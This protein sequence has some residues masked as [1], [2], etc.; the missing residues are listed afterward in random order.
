[1]DPLLIVFISLLQLCLGSK[2]DKEIVVYNESAKIRNS[3]KVNIMTPSMRNKE[4]VNLMENSKV[5][6]SRVIG[7]EVT[8]IEKLGGYLVALRYRDE[9]TCGGT[10]LEERFVVSA[11]HCFLGRTLKSAWTVSGGIS[12]LSETGVQVDLLDYVVPAVFREKSMHMDVAVILLKTPLKGDN[13]ATA[14]LCNRKLSEGLLLKVSGWGLID[15][16]ATSPYQTIRTVTVPVLNKKRCRK[17]YKKA[18]LL[19]HSMFCAGV[20]GTKDACTFDSGGP[21]IYDPPDEGKKELCGIVSFG[22]SC[23]SPKF[24]GVYTDVNYVKPFI[25]RTIMKFKESIAFNP[26]ENVN[27]KV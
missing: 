10:L 5:V 15:P 3:E 22:I 13:I 19:T 7:G 1:M 20:L 9:F 12:H 23:A 8:T 6:H 27:N 4:L 26:V 25:E 16:N 18:L 24:A 11:A 17:N 14:T 21:L 2:D